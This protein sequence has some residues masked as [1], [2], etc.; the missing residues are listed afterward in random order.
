[1]LFII[2]GNWSPWRLVQLI[3]EDASLTPVNLEVDKSLY[4][5]SFEI[6]CK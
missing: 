5:F 6:S 3:M 2:S 4:G 1:M